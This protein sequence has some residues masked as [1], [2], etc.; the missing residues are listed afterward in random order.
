MH[1]SAPKSKF[2]NDAVNPVF[3]EKLSTSSA[4]LLGESLTKMGK[5]AIFSKSEICDAY[6]AIANAKAQHNLYGMKWLEKIFLR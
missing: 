5:G 4:K 3:I 6:K 2:F 1:L